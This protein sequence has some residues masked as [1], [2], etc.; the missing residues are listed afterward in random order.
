[1]SFSSHVADQQGQVKML[2]QRHI[3]VPRI[4][5]ITLA[6]ALPEPGWV[7]EVHCVREGGKWYAVLVYENGRD[8]PD[9]QGAGEVIGVDVGVKTL[10]MTSN[11]EAYEN[12][13]W[14]A[15]TERQ[16]RRVNKAIARSRNL[17]PNVATKRR[18]RLYAKRARLLSKQ[19]NQRKTHHRQV[20]SAIAK[21]AG[22]VVVEE[23]LN[24][25]G[26]LRN[27]RLAK[28]MSDAGMG[29]FLAELGWQC[30]KRGVR[31]VK[32]GRMFPSTQLCARCGER[33]DERLELSVRTYR[34]EHCSWVC[35]RDHNAALNLKN[36][37]LALWATLK[38][39]GGASP[40]SGP[41]AT[42]EASIG[43]GSRQLA[44]IPG[45]TLRICKRRK[46]RNL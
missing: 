24:V 16:L 13:K 18:G 37:A 9:A 19:S 22:V 14:Y 6:E 46:Q 28:A 7:K 43:T 26:L 20:A 15:R 27:R 23:T 12:P 45:W 44:L 25:A 34:C 29:G 38:G 21:S 8:L 40:V 5:V 4:G 17:N 30:A 1:M 36:V 10:A 39:R 42:N 11:G 2:G 35:D 41:E 33:P 32:A 3:R 31:L